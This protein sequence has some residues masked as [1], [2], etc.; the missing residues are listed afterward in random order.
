MTKKLFLLGLLLLVAV[1]PLASGALA[2]D[3]IAY[4]TMNQTRADIVGTFDLGLSQATEEPANTSNGKLG[5]GYDFD[6]VNDGFVTGDTYTVTGDISVSMWVK[7]DTSDS[8]L[9]TQWASSTDNI[10]LSYMSN[11]SFFIW[12]RDNGNAEQL[13]TT[14]FATGSF[15]HI[16][17]V[18]NSSGNLSIYVN[19]ALQNT[20]STNGRSINNGAEAFNLGVNDIGA[21][22][23]EFDGVMD[24]VGIFD[25][26]LEKAQVEALYNSG[27]G[28][29]YPF[30]APSPPATYNPNLTIRAYDYFDN[31]TVE[32]FTVELNNGSTYSTS[33]GTVHI[34]NV[35][36]DTYVFNV[37]YSSYF[38]TT[39][40]VSINANANDTTFTKYVYPHQAEISFNAYKILSGNLL[41]NATFS[42]N[43]T[44]NT[45]FW[46]KASDGYVVLAQNT[47]F[48]NKS[49]T[50][51]VSVFDNYTINITNM[52]DAQLTIYP[53]DIL[54]NNTIEADNITISNSTYSY[55]Q[56]F[57]DKTNITVN[58]TTGKYNLVI[59][60][61]NRTSYNENITIS[62]TGASNYYAYMYAYNSLWVYAFD[63]ETAS[64]ILNFNVTVQKVNTSYSATGVN[65]VAKI[66]NITSGEYEV[67]V[68]ATGYSNG[69]YTVTMTD[70]SHQDL[71]AYLSQATNTI[72]FTFKDKNTN[73]VITGANAV[74]KR[75]INDTL[76]TIG[77]E[78]SDIAGLVRFYYVNGVEYTFV[79]TKAGYTS[80][81]FTL[82]PILSAY[83]VLL[84]PTVAGNTS[85][86][87]DDVY[88]SI[89]EHVF[90]NNYTS[91]ATVTFG[92]GSGT[93]EYYNVT[94]ENDYNTTTTSGTNANGETLN[95]TAFLIGVGAG[96]YT[97]V[98]IRYKSTLNTKEKTITVM[99][100]IEGFTPGL[101]SMS[102]IKDEINDLGDLEK[103]L[104][105]T[106]LIAFFAGVFALGGASVGEGLIGSAIG[107]VIGVTLCAYMGF[108]AWEVTYATLLLLLLIVA[109]RGV[110]N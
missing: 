1:T 27:T 19:G 100:A 55:T 76:T 108:F 91:F 64:T 110:N 12:L 69:V 93:L 43:G 82:E 25:V 22:S 72:T 44:G 88:Y 95:A 107:G 20:K 81:T 6:G 104:I 2:D 9:F 3:L 109:T 38:N 75:Y 21:S 58:I 84:T 5:Y 17:G 65:G 89:D 16:V 102:V 7:P 42:V 68:I 96:S 46:L 80:R 34:N 30:T 105:A 26:A 23:Q 18:W 71:N 32:A 92:S 8:Y 41:P 24:E 66:N 86:I 39:N 87:L 98:I 101:G 51:N 31:S 59:N 4:F 33:N 14:G 90:R 50:F 79:I 15:Y 52:F 29:A 11:T 83:T 57:Y 35:T 48:F 56:T 85:V 74:Q 62:A 10:R 54:N 70:N 106:V 63:Q 78:N 40:A 77:S 47:G 99:Y 103:A 73:A 13:Y 28:V 60:D 61:N 49:V 45:T 94:I 53:R 97:K 36:I 37:T 67:T